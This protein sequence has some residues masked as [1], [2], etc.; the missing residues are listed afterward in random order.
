[1]TEAAAAHSRVELVVM[2]AVLAGL[3][4]GCTAPARVAG[5]EP[6]MVTPTRDG[7]PGAAPGSCWGKTVSPA[8]VQ[9]VQDKVLDKPAKVNPDGT[10]ASLPV[11]RTVERQQIVIPRKDNWFETPCPEVFTPEFIAS[12]QRALTA[13]NAYGGAINGQMDVSTR[14]AIRAYQ[15]PEGPDSDLLTLQTARQ[16]G[17]VAAPLASSNG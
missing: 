17:L 4:A 13:R 16:L 1:M 5:P 9:T 12:L 2:S 15:A 14:A 3:L 11:Y 8:V 6:G 7:P 10:L